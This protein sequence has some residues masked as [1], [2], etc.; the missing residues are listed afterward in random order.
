MWTLIASQL[1]YCRT[2]FAIIAVVALGSASF[3]TWVGKPE[4]S[5]IWQLVALG[6]GVS[7]NVLLW[8]KDQ[9]E[10]RMLMWINLPL[11]LEKIAAMRL[12]SA[13][14]IQAAAGILAA[15]GL[16][17]TL[18]TRGLSDPQAWPEL[19]GT[20]G[21]ALLTVLMI[22]LSEELTLW[23][24]PRHWAVIAVNIVAPVVFLTLAF[25]SETLFHSWSGAL[26]AHILAVVA[27]AA[28]YA[29][30]LRR[31]SFLVG[32]SPLTGLPRDWSEAPARR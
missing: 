7:A 27:A 4:G 32:L 2:G 24:A 6:F 29:L 30:F 16:S 15:L 31:R 22:Y 3:V 28:A 18:L 14:L 8:A 11:S 19:L 10:R 21:F 5:G 1:N 17:L 20:H 9:K 23:A 12:L 26:L 13:A 25:S